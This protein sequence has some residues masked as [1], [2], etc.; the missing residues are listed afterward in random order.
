[1]KVI[2]LK[3]HDRGIT[4]IKYNKQGDLLFSASK[5]KEITVW[6]A[7]N[8][9]RIGTMVGHNGAVYAI[10]VTRDSTQLLSGSADNRVKIWDVASGRELYSISSLNTPVRSL[11]L[12][13]G[14]DRF[15]VATDAVLGYKATIQT[16]KYSKDREELSQDPIST[17]TM[18]SK[19]KV[20]DIMWTP[21]NQHIVAG[22]SDGRV[23]VF[24]AETQKQIHEIRD[25]HEG[26]EIKR[27]QYPENRY[28]FLTASTDHTA[29]LYDSRTFKLMKTYE[30]G[31]PCNTAAMH[32]DINH[33]FLAGGQAA[34]DVTT[35]RVDNIQFSTRIYHKIFSEELGLIP[36]HFGP[37]NDIA[38]NPDGKSFSTGGEDGYVRMNILD[39]TY[40][41]GL[42]DKV[43]FKKLSDRVSVR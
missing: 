28:C 15:M 35:T 4:Q 31:R 11:K 21:L 12:S 23:L 1:M 19:F 5:G 32:P 10:D 42:S 14:E 27:I 26:S 40:Y 38:V 20:L 17:I 3:G 25:N 18:E 22:T 43:Y 9:E 16:F 41:E 13:Q 7:N 29:R 2:L 36:G 8:G 6:W 30:T 39:D 24:D 34:A 37:V 33:V